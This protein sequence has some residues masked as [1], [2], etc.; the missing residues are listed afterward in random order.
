M[1]RLNLTDAVRFLGWR[2]DMPRVY[3]DLDVVA[4]SSRN[5]G[6]PVSLIE[7]LA[8]ARPV[9]AT[10]VGGVPEVVI[11]GV[12]GLTVPASDPRALARCAC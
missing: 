1:R 12:T 7:A 11:D 5:E 9:V 10:A 3:A 4:L 8:A 2:H 6:S